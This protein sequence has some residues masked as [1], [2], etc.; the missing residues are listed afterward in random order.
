MATSAAGFAPIGTA[1][2]SDRSAIIGSTRAA[3]AIGGA[4]AATAARTSARAALKLV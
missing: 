2:Y 3:R 1:T 4:P